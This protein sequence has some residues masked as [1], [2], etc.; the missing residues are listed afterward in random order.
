MALKAEFKIYWNIDDKSLKFQDYSSFLK[1]I[2]GLRQDLN[3]YS[4]KFIFQEVKYAQNMQE[5]RISLY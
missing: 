4:I 1:K 2:P 5:F 3:L